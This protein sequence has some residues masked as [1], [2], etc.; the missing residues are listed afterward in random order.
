MK[1]I[2]KLQRTIVTHIR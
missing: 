1:F 2:D